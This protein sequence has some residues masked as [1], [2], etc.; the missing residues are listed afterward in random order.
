MTIVH[1]A[2]K[3]EYETEIRSGSYG[4]SSLKRWGYIHCSDLDTYYLVAPNFK[5]DCAEK[6][7]LVIDTDRL[8]S[9]VRW[10]DGGGL[11][12]PHIYGPLNQAAILAV[13]PHLLQEQGEW[14]PNDELKQYAVNGFRRPWNGLD[15]ESG[16]GDHHDDAP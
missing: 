14:I 5:D 12:F 2:N 10:E 11:D 1:V 7:I 8:T 4:A 3:H 6:V 15:A 13:L 16:T 9:E